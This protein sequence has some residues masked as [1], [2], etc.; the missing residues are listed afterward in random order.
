MAGFL[1][2]KTPLCQTDVACFESTSRVITDRRLRTLGEL[3]TYIA[4]AATM[5][6][7]GNSVSK[8]F[9]FN[10]Y[11]IPF[12]LVYFCSVD[13]GTR[14]DNGLERRSTSESDFSEQDTLVTYT[15]QS[16]VGIPEEHPLAPR[17]VD[18]TTSDSYVW[19]FGKMAKEHTELNMRLS[20]QSLE[21]IRHQGWPDLPTSAVAVP[22]FG[23]R[24]SS[25]KPVMISMLIMGLNPRQVFDDDYLSWFRI[26]SRH[27]AAAMNVMRGLENAARKAE[28]LAAQ[29]RHRTDFLN[30]FVSS[31]RC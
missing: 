3:D 28:D 22:I 20:D 18:H 12:A 4:G 25:G 8:A 17:V 26:C 11:D 1:N 5:N 24:E 10:A 19:P 15:L 31:V 23:A 2:R 16:T 6:D 14:I 27:I 29:N 30:T 7:L 21:G 13:F 9:T